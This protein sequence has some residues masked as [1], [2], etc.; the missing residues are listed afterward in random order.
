MTHLLAFT[1]ISFLV[2]VIPGPSV[3]FTVGRALTVG[4]REALLTVGGNAVGAYLQIVAVAF[5]AGALVQAS[6]LAFSAIKLAG[7]A[8]LVFLGV[9]AIRHRRRMSVTL[10]TGRVSVRPAKVM[11]DGF[12]VGLTNPKTI[13]FFLA[14]LPQVVDPAGGHAMLQMLALGSIF[15]AIA[16]VSDSIWALVA[17]TAR[18][19]FA[20]SPRR[21]AAIGGAGGLAMV[22]VGVALAATGRK[23]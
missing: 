22:S 9:Q 1:L 16:L 19:W 12:V 11:A 2:I 15:P 20:Q 7:A 14:V 10:A 6:A 17:G 21:L 3:L 23:D 4:R 13:V 18:N 5:G 8:Y